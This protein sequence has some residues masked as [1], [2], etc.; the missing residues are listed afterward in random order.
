VTSPAVALIS[1]V[2][3]VWCRDVVVAAADGVR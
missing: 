2:R 1:R 3:L